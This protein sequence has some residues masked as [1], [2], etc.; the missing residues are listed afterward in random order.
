MTPAKR[1]SPNLIYNH[2]TMLRTIKTISPI[3]HELHQEG[4]T[5]VLATGFFDLLH[6]EHLNFL[7]KARKEGDVLVVGVESDTRAREIKG[8]GRPVQDQQ[9]RARNLTPYADH[10]VLLPDN[11]STPTAHESLISAVKPDVFAVSSHTAH[12]D[13]KSEL[14]EKYGGQLLVVHSHNKSVSTTA[15][16]NKNQL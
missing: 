4:R 1:F 9:L 2:L 8:E 12:Q 16:I 10:L 11:F 7:A 13:K 3:C 5:I 6:Q 14:A 15:L